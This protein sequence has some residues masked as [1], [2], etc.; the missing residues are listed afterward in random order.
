VP[1]GALAPTLIV[2]VEFAVEPMGGWIFRGVKVTVTSW[3]NPA[4]LSARVQLKPIEVAVTMADLDCP[5]EIVC[6][7][8]ETLIATSVP[9]ANAGWVT[10]RKVRAKAEASRTLNLKELHNLD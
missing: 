3:G 4:T 6:E 9:Q 1:G 5:G 7:L 10:S 8:G 2:I